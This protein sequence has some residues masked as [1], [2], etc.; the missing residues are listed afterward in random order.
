MT[1]SL[2]AGGAVVA[3]RS[4][5]L[6]AIV[7]LS[8]AVL[9]ACVS[10]T[11]HESPSPVTTQP[12]AAVADSPAAL[13]KYEIESLRQQ[14][15]ACWY[16]DSDTHFADDPIVEVHVELLPNGTVQ[17]AEVV[18][19]ARMAS[20]ADYRS[21]AQAALRA[22][23]RCSPYKLPEDKYQDWKSIVFT[24]NLRGLVAN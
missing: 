3:C 19:K 17:S 12:T 15:P 23:L 1:R 24:F 21:A 5:S 22:V 6:R 2:S 16:F 7:I 13:S 18:D 10:T 4:S 11:S 14:I 8:A 20:D 9:A